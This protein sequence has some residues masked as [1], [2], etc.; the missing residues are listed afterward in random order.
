VEHPLHHTKGAFL[1]RYEIFYLSLSQSILAQVDRDDSIVRLV[2]SMDD[3][4]SFVKEA[5]LIKKI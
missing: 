3:V 4:Y 1:V 2:E 5:E